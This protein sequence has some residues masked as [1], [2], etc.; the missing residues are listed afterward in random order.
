HAFPSD[1]ARRNTRSV[2]PETGG[3]TARP[4]LVT[5]PARPAEGRGRSPAGRSAAESAQLQAAV[6]CDPSYASGRPAPS[7][8]RVH[9]KLFAGCSVERVARSCYGYARPD[10][11]MSGEW[12]R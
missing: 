4:R 5:A 10:V 6:S 11:M 2:R 9:G 12:F 8:D 3:P 1:G 7:F